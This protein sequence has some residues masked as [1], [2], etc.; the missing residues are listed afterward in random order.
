MSTQ[1]A[2]LWPLYVG[3]FLGPFGAPVVT[4][5]LPEMQQ[6][7]GHTIDQLSMSLSAYLF[8]FAG[9]MLISGTL[10]ERFGR[11]R[12]VQV[13]YIVYALASVACALAP[14]FELLVVARVVQGAA[15]AFTTPVLVAAI[16]DAVAPGKLGRS[17]GLFGSLQATGQAMAPL[18]G[19]VAA[20]LDWRLAFWGTAVVAALLAVFP[21]PNAAAAPAHAT[22]RWKVLANRQL[23]V[24]SVC[25]FLSFLTAM[26]MAVVAALYVRDVFELGPTAT[27]LIVA[28]FGLT[29][30]LSGRRL[31][32]LMDRRGVIPVGAVM[33][34]G[35][36]VFAMVTGLVG[37]LALASP[38][39]LVLV[40]LF[41]G[42]AGAAATGTRTLSQ[43]LAATS[44]PSNRSGATSVMLA[45]QFTGA[46]L[47]PVLWVP[48]YTSQ[49][50]PHGGVALVASGTTALIAALILGVV[51]RTN[52]LQKT[53]ESA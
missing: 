5:M 18:A 43:T 47:A 41:I 15:N 53:A 26:S 36:G 11:K 40:V 19:G 1:K 33:N 21:P 14:S 29:G 6:D 25:A 3:G 12:T 27:G 9:L 22:N 30:L 46:A 7:L 38:I 50:V 51:H 52:F 28:V 10:A 31:G 45:C 49:P 35:L 2:R 37:T 4:T 24:A 42:L 23:G 13:G 17:L 39:P 8:P 48:V 44:A 16:A 32:A 34:L 20:N